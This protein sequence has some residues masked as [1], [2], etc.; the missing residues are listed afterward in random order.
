MRSA[1]IP[2]ESSR[3]SDTADGESTVSQPP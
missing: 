2:R 1:A 3:A